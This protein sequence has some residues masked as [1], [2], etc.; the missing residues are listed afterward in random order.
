MEWFC[1]GCCTW[2]SDPEADGCY[3][4][5]ADDPTSP[6]ICWYCGTRLAEVKDGLEYTKEPWDSP[7]NDKPYIDDPDKLP[8]ISAQYPHATC[9]EMCGYCGVE[10]VIPAYQESTCPVCGQPIIPCSM[11]AVLK[12][13]GYWHMTCHDKCPYSKEGSE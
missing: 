8:M 7:D 9:Y 11:C 13:D 1:P 3:H 2:T 10:V 6:W 4:E 5:R 12:D